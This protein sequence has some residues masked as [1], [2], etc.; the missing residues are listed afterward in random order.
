MESLWSEPSHRTQKYGQATRTQLAVFGALLLG[1]F[2]PMLLLTV[3]SGRV[4]GEEFRLDTF[5]RRQFE[6]YRLPFSEIRVSPIHC[7]EGTGDAA[8]KAYLAKG[9]MEA[10]KWSQDRGD[11]GASGRICHSFVIG[12]FVI[13][14][15][16][17]FVHE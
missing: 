10:A 11:L 6:F 5:Q 1:G 4:T 9:Y 12:Y 17:R 14:H 7:E 3:G 16:S 8:L 13:R 2:L 15:S